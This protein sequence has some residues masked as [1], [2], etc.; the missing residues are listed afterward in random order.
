MDIDVICGP[1][2]HKMDNREEF[3]PWA[4]VTLA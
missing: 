3:R 1:E 2:W 4:A